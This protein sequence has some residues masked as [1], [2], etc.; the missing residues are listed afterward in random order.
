MPKAIVFGSINMDVVT[1]VDKHPDVGETVFGEGVHYFPGGKGSNQAVAC[2]RLGAKTIMVGVVGADAFG[3]EML[4]FQK[5]EGI[6]TE[7]VL[8]S[9]AAVTGTAFI[10]VSKSSDNS[11]VV[12]P[13]ANYC[14]PKDN[15][16]YD[17]ACEGDVVVSQFEIPDEVVLEAFSA[18]KR[19]GATTI[20]NPAPVREISSSILECTDVLVVN[21]HE[22]AS[23]T[24]EYVD[25]TCDDT[26]FDSAEK[27]SSQGVSAVVVTL[28]KYGVRVYKGGQKKR[29]NARSVNAVDTT[30][31]GDTFIG[32]MV[33]SQLSGL[34]IWE[35]AE[36]GNVAA[37]ISVTRQGAASSIPSLDE[38]KSICGGGD[39]Q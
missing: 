28:G 1:Y 2:Q 37:S 34:D 39:G 26:V 36:V 20:L 8:V 14:W 18:A 16:A 21:E 31:A 38:I 35:A 23:L 11:I 27:L 19:Q 13:G 9:D 4:S 10:T 29:I 24:G 5:G 22:L 3:E 15:G 6:D 7:F 33:A 25:P 30:G 17:V 32:G 12:V